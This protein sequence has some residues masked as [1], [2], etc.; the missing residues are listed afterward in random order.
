ML[1]VCF[2]RQSRNYTKDLKAGT[3]QNLKAGFTRLQV[4]LVL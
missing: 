3:E 2:F 1:M 4:M